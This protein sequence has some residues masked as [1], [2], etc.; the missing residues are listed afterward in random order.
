M[1][2]F[3]QI[4]AKTYEE[5]TI[6]NN[7]FVGLTKQV[8]VK[9]IP[10]LAEKIIISNSK[11]EYTFVLRDA[12]W[13]N[14]EKI[15]AYDFVSSWDKLEKLTSK[16]NKTSIFKILGISEYKVLSNRTLFVRLN[17]KNEDLLKFFSSSIFFPY[18]N[19]FEYKGDFSNDLDVISSG[20]YKLSIKR[21]ENKVTLIQNE[22]YKKDIDINYD[23]INILNLDKKEKINREEEVVISSTYNLLDNK[24]ELLKNT[25]YRY[26]PFNQ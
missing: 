15:S 14:G 4:L 20:P 3:R 17:R 24:N 19:D 9:V 22:Y 11:L 13:S 21:N 25:N 10:S 18:K 8:G 5:K 26:L 7:I 1:K 23:K 2:A 12:Y 16:S 6:V